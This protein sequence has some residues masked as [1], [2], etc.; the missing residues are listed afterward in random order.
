MDLY[1]T[2]LFP[3]IQGEALVGKPPVPLTMTTVSVEKVPSN[4]GVEETKYILYFKETKKG[5][6]LNKTNAARI[7]ALYGRETDDWAGERIALYS[8]KV[9]AFG[10]NHNA[11]RVDERKPTPNGQSHDDPFPTPE[12]NPTPEADIAD[13]EDVFPVQDETTE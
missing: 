13:T 3:Y 6:I 12:D 7:I 5:L 2:D 8:E 9:N 4:R 11:V 10:K 1:K